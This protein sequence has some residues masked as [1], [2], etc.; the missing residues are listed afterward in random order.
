[1]KHYRLADFIHNPFV[2]AVIITR[3]LACLFIPFFPL[4]GMLL[5]IIFDCTDWVI[6][7]MG[8]LPINFYHVL[9]K[10]LDMLGYVILIIPLINTPIF[11]IYILLLL[12]RFIG[13]LI[14]NYT[15]NRR[16]F[17]LFPNI[18]EYIVLIYFINLRLNLNLDIF[19]INILLPI[20]AFKLIH[21]YFIHFFQH[22]K[23]YSIYQNWGNRLKLHQKG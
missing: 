3:V 20:I 19:S 13:Q 9:D 6:L 12:Y 11:L 1:M 7:G 21:E 5:N 10:P 22:E 8:N 18:G 16:W 14:V 15:K 4:E 2:I 17:M 23:H